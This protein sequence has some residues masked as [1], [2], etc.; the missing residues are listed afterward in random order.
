MQTELDSIQREAASLAE[1]EEAAGPTAELAE[2]T[3]GL[4]SQITSVRGML[5]GM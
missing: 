1:R 4:L 3:G 2:E 5:N